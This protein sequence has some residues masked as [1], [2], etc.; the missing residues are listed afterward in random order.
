MHFISFCIILAILA[1]L[2][3]ADS[4]SHSS[5]DSGLSSENSG[6]FSDGSS[7]SEEGQCCSN[8][9]CGI[10]CC[11]C[12]GGCNNTCVAEAEASRSRSISGRHYIQSTHGPYVSH[13]DGSDKATLDWHRDSS[14]EWLIED[15][16]GKIALTTTQSPVRYASANPDGSI[17]IVDKIDNGALW[18]PIKGRIWS[19]SS[20]LR[21]ALRTWLYAAVNGT[22]SSQTV[23]AGDEN[24][25][26][27]LEPL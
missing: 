5:E 20:S 27:R 14:A 17:V 15:H 9:P 4:S 18:T 19:G 13:R 16:D 6:E 2:T 12:D 3:Q 8:G 23:Y 24:N 26:F 1:L 10:F 7:S 25:K 22:L 21:T 11:G